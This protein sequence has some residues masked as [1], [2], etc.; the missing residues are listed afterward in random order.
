[1]KIFNIADKFTDN[2]ES[3]F[4][5]FQYSE[6]TKEGFLFSSSLCEPVKDAAN[7]AVAEVQHRD[8]GTEMTPL[9]SSTTTRCHTPIK[10]SSPARHNT[11]DNRSGP[12][13]ANSTCI[14]ISELKDCHFAKLD[15]GAQFN[16]VASKW[17]SR[18]EEEEEISKSLR[19]FEMDGGRKSIEECRA[20]VWEDEE[21]TKSCI[22]W[23][24]S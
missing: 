5:N 11:P 12:L 23:I 17:S 21:W 22:R 14:D 7:E 2:V 13:V 18:E 15:R 8:V 4:P 1:M 3:I 6:P 24:K 10:S 20:S 9:G 19:H 16:S